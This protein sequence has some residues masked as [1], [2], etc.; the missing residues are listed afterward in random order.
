MGPLSATSCIAATC[1]VF[2]LA[3][4][5]KADD[6]NTFCKSIGETARLIMERRQADVPMSA[7]M[8]AIDGSK[9]PEAV[10]KFGRELVILA[11][12]KPDFS[13]EENQNEAIA[14]FVNEVELACYQRFGR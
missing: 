9:A 13:V 10:G 1:I 7:M 11:Y 3:T 4:S 2:A 6:A 8:Q 12:Q 14:E 5:A